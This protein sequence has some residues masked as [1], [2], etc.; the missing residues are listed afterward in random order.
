MVS[1]SSRFM[2]RKETSEYIEGKFGVSYKPNTLARLACVGGGPEYLK[3]GQRVV[4]TPE[5]T[6]RWIAGMLSAHPPGNAA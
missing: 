6:D 5:S 4:Y 3:I 2:N 1:H